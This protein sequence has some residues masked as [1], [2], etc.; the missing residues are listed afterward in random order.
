M[1]IL[2][3]ESSCDDTAVAIVEN[4][5]K[6][7]SSTASSQIDIH[8]IYGGVVPEIASRAHIESITPLTKLAL[9]EANLGLENID[10]IAVTY[11]PGLIGS[12][13]VGLG[14]AKGLAIS[15]GLPLIPVHHIK[16]HI[17]SLYISNPELKPPFLCLVVSGG[18][19]HILEVK[20]YTKIDIIAK[21]RDDAAGEA[22]D[23][24]GRRLGFDY[25]GGIT[26]DKIAENGNSDAFELPIPLKNEENTLDFSFSG[27]KTAMINIINKFEQKNVPLPIEDMCATFRKS[28]VDCLTN[29]F[30]CAAKQLGYKTLAIAGG[31]SANSLLRR[32]LQKKCGKNSYSFFMPEKKY[33]GDNA[34]MVGS[35]A[36]YEFLSEKTAPLSINAL[37]S[38]I[39]SED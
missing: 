13:L 34:A 6:V 9:K 39:I 4:G 15:T 32:E 1:K 21:T 18:H 19:S 12:L 17:A 22:F 36:Y 26:L 10:A 3:I 24:I 35:Q 25:P 31:V 29:N 2:A 5:R 11:A 16:S 8:K 37:A 30:I 14:F 23:K 7:L 38:K 33:C 27:L 20:D 28:V